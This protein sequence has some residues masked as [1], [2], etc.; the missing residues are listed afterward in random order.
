M[1]M[2]TEKLAA[3]IGPSYV[4]SFFLG[5]LIGLT[6]VPPPKS[7]RTRRLMIN[8]YINNVGKTS[9]RFGNNVGGAIFMYIMIGKFMNFVFLEELQEVSVPTQNAVFGGITGA[10][11]K[12]TRGKRAMG[13]ST[14]LG[15]SVGSMY[16]YF[17]GKGYFRFNM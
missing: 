10:L 13:L 6:K 3:T 14:L 9:S 15:A 12:C 1:S 7:R 8:S 5:G 2:F 4:A 17:W 11:Y 16:A